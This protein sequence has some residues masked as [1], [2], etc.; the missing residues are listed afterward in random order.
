MAAT[1]PVNDLLDG[2]VGLDVECL[3]RICA[4]ETFTAPAHLA[5]TGTPA[6]DGGFESDIVGLSCCGCNDEAQP[7]TRLGIACS[8]A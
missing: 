2:H 3:D 1:V 5:R 4:S 6:R 7:A 8:P